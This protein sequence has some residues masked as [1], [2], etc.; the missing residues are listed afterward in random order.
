M[1]NTPPADTLRD[2]NLKATIWQNEG[3][4]G[5]YFTTT[6]SRSYKDEEGNYLD[7]Q[8]FASGD[9]LRVS[10]LARQ[11]HNHTNVLKRDAYRD[12]DRAAAIEN[13]LKERRAG[14][15]KEADRER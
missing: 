12:N 5:P 15:T 11:A 1:A 10:E 14:R 7:T 4:K 3:E 8:S 13:R 6:L 9:L 2:G